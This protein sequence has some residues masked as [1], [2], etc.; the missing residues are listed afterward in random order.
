MVKNTQLTEIVIDNDSVNISFVEVCQHYAISEDT[1]FEMLEYGLI[2]EIVAPNR[3]LKFNQAHLQRII[4]ALRLHTDLDI[5]T[6]GVI[7]ALELMDELAELRKQL[8]LLQRHIR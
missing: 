7:L 8:A 2:P 3:N 6:H 1:L 5:N 4:S